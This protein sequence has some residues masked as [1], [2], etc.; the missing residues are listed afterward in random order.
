MRLLAPNAVRFKQVPGQ[1]LV[2]Y[3]YAQQLAACAG[4]S[5][6]AATQR[7]FVNPNDWDAETGNSYGAVNPNVFLPYPF[8]TTTLAC[9]S[10]VFISPHHY[11]KP[12]GLLHNPTMVET[13]TLKLIGSDTRLY[14][15]VA[16]YT[17]VIAKLLPYNY[18]LYS[19]NS[20]ELPAFARMHNTYIGVSP[21]VTAER[22][23]IMP[24]TAFAWGEGTQFQADHPL[25]AWQKQMPNSPVGT[26]LSGGDSGSP[27]FCYIQGQPVIL[28]FV[29]SAWMMGSDKLAEL[30][31]QIA[32]KMRELAAF[33][34]DPLAQ[35]YKP[36]TVD[37][38]L[39]LV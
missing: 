7:A 15:Q 17:G 4:K 14:Y 28:S 6:G 38:E 20:A 19:G 12:C 25:F 39:L 32:T 21:D 29:S 30:F 34:G 23:W 31:W 8:S 5:P 35:S 2:D 36:Q 9:N 33:Y 10:S 22:Q 11:L 3:L 37:L 16:E 1:P 27:V 18:G 26:M 13:D 24:V